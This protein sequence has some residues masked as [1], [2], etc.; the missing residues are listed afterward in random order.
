M[1][2]IKRKRKYHILFE[3]FWVWGSRQIPRLTIL[4]DKRYIQRATRAID[5]QAD[6]GM[7]RTLWAVWGPSLQVSGGK[8]LYAT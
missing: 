1:F 3:R 2:L 8:G 6:S 4:L 5:R 7:V